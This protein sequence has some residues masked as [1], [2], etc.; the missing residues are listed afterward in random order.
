MSPENPYL[1]GNYAPVH[2]EIVASD[3]EVIG[4]LPSDLSGVFVRTGANPM[5]RPKGRY[6]WFDGDGM[7]HAVT[8][9]GGCATYRNRFIET[10]G[11]AV[12][13][14]AG[15]AVYT[16]LLERPNPRLPGGPF[17]NTGN[18]DIVFHAGQLLALWWMG[19][20]VYACSLP[21]LDT[22]GIQDY[23]GRLERGMTAHAK[24][25][26]RTGQ[27]VFIDYG[28]RPPYLTCGSV[29]RTGNLEYQVTVDL[30]GQSLQ[31]DLAITQNHA[32][33]I[34]PA[35]IIDRSRPGVGNEKVVFDRGRPT[36]LGLFERTGRKRGQTPETQADV[37]WF[38]TEPCY[39][40]HTINA[41][42]QGDDVVVVGCRI[43]D[44]LVGDPNLGA[45]AKK[46]ASLAHLRIEPY[47]YRWVLNRKT[48]SVQEQQLDDALT[49][50]PRIND[51]YLGVRS[52]YTYNPRVHPGETLLFDG[53]IKYD[54]DG[55]GTQVHAY[56]PG[57]FGGE[58]VFAPRDGGQGEDDGYLLTYVSEFASG[59]SEVQVFDARR[60]E[61]GPIA[62]VV[63]P[64]RVPEGFHAQWVPA[65]SVAASRPL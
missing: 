50:F 53:F 27:L 22:L 31:H 8:I 16:G 14:E 65:A 55:S 23:G 35:L 57:W 29:D 52:R 26:P 62:R 21:D 59:R 32:V 40:Y 25:D 1:S 12:E 20:D 11:L 61:D 17:K 30:P 18:T 36:R 15:Q 10:R 63:V 44:P 6:H 24:V 41:W 4:A 7:I 39:M 46:V 48:G 38:A 49:E 2:T 56:T 47:L 60:P 9:G 3:L 58:V 13:R 42:E 33:L 34:D 51:H 5:F 43:A 28:P 54:L 19:G 64:Q 45:N 37:T